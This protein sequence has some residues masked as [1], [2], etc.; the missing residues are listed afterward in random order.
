MLKQI[1]GLQKD[2]ALSELTAEA[3]E[4]QAKRAASAAVGMARGL[5]ER[6]IQ[7]DVAAY[8]EQR[9]AGMSAYSALFSQIY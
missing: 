6:N 7:R 3:W 2:L 1:E 9:H 5:S 4:K 8:I